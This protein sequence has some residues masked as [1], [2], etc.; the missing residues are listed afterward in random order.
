M[1]KTMGKEIKYASLYIDLKEDSLSFYKQ[2]LDF[3]VFKDVSVGDDERWWVLKKEEG[4]EIGLILI[5]SDGNNHENNTLII[6]THDCIL[7]YCKLRDN[8]LGNLSTPLYSTL[9]LSFNFYDPSGNKI[10][11]L[12][13][14]K[15]EELKI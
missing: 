2:Y 15:Y 7:E 1:S 3:N 5:Q 12:E 4:E 10:V 9:G 13:E 6:N 14:R 8:G 11:V